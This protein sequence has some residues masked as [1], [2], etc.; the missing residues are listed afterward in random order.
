MFE[1]KAIQSGYDSKN[2]FDSLTPPIYLTSTFTF[3]SLEQEANRFAGVEEGRIYSRLSNPTV[4]ILEEQIISNIREHKT[5]IYIET[6][7]KSNN[8]TN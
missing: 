5:C 7:I 3:P 4:T 6:P 1:T 2:H 8:E